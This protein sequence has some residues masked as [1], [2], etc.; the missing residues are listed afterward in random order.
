MGPSV[1][2]MR[3]KAAL[4]RRSP[5][6]RFDDDTHAPIKVLVTG[7]VHA[8]PRSPQDAFVPLTYGLGYTPPTNSRTLVAPEVLDQWPIGL[9]FEALA[10]SVT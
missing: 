2:T 1:T 9:R 8:E 6:A 5:W 3:A 4:A 7:V 10:E